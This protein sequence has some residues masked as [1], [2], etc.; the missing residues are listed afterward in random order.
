MLLKGADMNDWVVIFFSG[1]PMW[2]YGDLIKTLH[3]PDGQRIPAIACSAVSLAAN[4]FVELK[5]VAEG[6]NHEQTLLVRQD[7]VLCAFRLTPKTQV[8]FG[9][10][11]TER[12]MEPMADS[13]RSLEQPSSSGAGGMT[14][15]A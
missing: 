3:A 6:T 11:M 13:S 14:G 10:P 15:T 7:H 2:P 4:A 9:V 8:G 12:Y 1:A 5:V